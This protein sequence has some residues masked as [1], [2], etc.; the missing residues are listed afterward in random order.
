M[1]DITEAPIDHAS[2]TERVRSN[3]AG[4]VCMFLGTV[5][6]ITGTRRTVALAYEAYAE[7]ALKKMAE[8]ESE[9]RHRWPVTGVAGLRP[10]RPPYINLSAAPCRRRGSS[11]GP[12]L[13]A[14]EHDPWRFDAARQRCP[15][16]GRRA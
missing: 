12:V 8:L 7:M 2:V 3:R 14:P 1:I 10:S 15:Q 16:F 9:A 4:A 11:A 6:E 13:G 5:R